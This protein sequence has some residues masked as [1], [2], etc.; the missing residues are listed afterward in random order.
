MVEK[1]LQVFASFLP[2]KR[3][4]FARFCKCSLTKR[5][6]TRIRLKVF[7]SFL[8]VRPQNADEKASRPQ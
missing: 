5:V 6:A 7:A 3:P 2:P 8:Q 1:V 4:S